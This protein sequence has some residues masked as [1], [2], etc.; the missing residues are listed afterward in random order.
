MDRASIKTILRDVF[1]RNF[2]MEDIGPWVSIRCVLAPWTHQKR[3]DTSP[4][5]GVSVNE[6]DTS[7]F[8]C[9]SCG[10]PMPFHAMLKR[11]MDYSGEDLSGLIE[12]LEEQAYLGP[13]T[14]PTWDSL[15]HSDQ[16]LMP[17]NEGIF[18]DLYDS[19]C[20]HPYLQERGVE[21]STAE[22]LELLFDPKDPADSEARIL[23]PV[24]GPEG[25]LYGF[26]GRAINPNAKLKVRD[27][28]GLPKASCVLGSHLVTKD[29][30]DCI[31]V[32]EGLFDYACM[33]QQGYHGCAVMHSTMT[34]AQ[35][36]II[37]GLSKPTY[38]FYDNDLAGAKGSAMASKLLQN[39]VPTFVVN[40]PRVEI[41]DSS[42]EGFHLVKDP[43]E[44][45]RDEIAFMIR[46]AQLV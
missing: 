27:Y 21:N 33:H 16:I 41:E 3:K 7:V 42:E 11:Y 29:N 22:R 15:K 9:F 12:E 36:E 13:R 28:N 6:K 46:K 5:A 23:F 45:I 30:P 35:V 2:Y 25:L 20:G 19:A 17:I 32:V 10:Q 8:N 18:I 34:P 24:R 40:Y 1:G 43:G 26:S 31:A 39:Y 4:S 14:I 44:L 38:L 37:R